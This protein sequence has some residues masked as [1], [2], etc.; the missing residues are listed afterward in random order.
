MGGRHA[1]GDVER[2]VAMLGYNTVVPGRD[3]RQPRNPQVS[4][5][6]GPGREPWHCPCCGTPVGGSAPPAQRQRPDIALRARPGTRGPTCSPLEALLS[7]GTDFSLFL[8]SPGLWEPE[9]TYALRTLGRD[10]RG[11]WALSLTW[12]CWAL[13]EASACQARGNLEPSRGVV[14]TGLWVPASPS[15]AGGTAHLMGFRTLGG[16]HGR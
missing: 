4:G 5:P 1:G 8:T 12:P 2:Y 16:Q 13:S 6:G 10:T 14:P 3:R 9:G 15:P 7:K 11:L